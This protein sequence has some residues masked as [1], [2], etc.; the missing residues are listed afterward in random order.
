MTSM[1]HVTVR[2]PRRQYTL[3]ERLAIGDISDVYRATAGG[4]DYVMKVSRIEGGAALLGN[5]W[6]ALGAVLA[7]A[8]DNHYARYF[9]SPVESFAGRD[10]IRKRVNVFD[11]RPGLH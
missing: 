1:P 3:L 5:E 9:P 2:S 6:Q 7:E 10:Q 11:H 8:G 4:R